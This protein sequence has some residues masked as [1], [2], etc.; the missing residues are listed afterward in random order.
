[1][2]LSTLALAE[3]LPSIDEPLRTGVRSSE[4][5]A[6]VIGIEDYVDLPDVPYATADAE[7]VH[8]LLVYTR[9]IP[10]SRARLLTG[11]VN[12]EAILEAVAEVARETSGRVFVYF[13][14]HGAA[15]TVSGE[16]LLLGFDT[17]ASASSF[18]S[19]A[20]SVSRLLASGPNVVLIADACYGAAGRTGETKAEGRWMVPVKA[21]ER[22]WV[23]AGPNEVAGPLDS[24]AH[25]AFT[26]L[27]VGALRGWADGEQ[28]DKPDGQVTGEEAQLYV[29]R[30][31]RE[32]QLVSQ[33]PSLSSEL[34]GLVFTRGA[35]ERGPELGATRDF[36]RD[37]AE[38]DRRRREREA[39][40]Q[41]EREAEARLAEKEA[42]EARRKKARLEAAESSFRAS[43]AAAWAK[44]EPLAAGG[45]EEG[46]EA[47]ELFLEHYAGGFELDG[48]T[49]PVQL[50][51][52]AEARRA[53]SA[54]KKS[55]AKRPS[56]PA[57]KV[58]AAAKSGGGAASQAP[59][60][61]CEAEAL[62]LGSA[63]RSARLDAQAAAAADSARVLWS[64][65][66]AEAKACEAQDAGKRARCAE[67]VDAFITRT[68]SMTVTLP[69]GTEEVTTR[70]GPAHPAFGPANRLVAVPALEEAKV[71][72]ARL[73]APAPAA[74]NT[75]SAKTSGSGAAPAS[76][77]R[78]VATAPAKEPAEADDAAKTTVR[79]AE[80][81]TTVKAGRSGSGLRLTGTLL[82][83]APLLQGRIGWRTPSRFAF[84]VGV[85]ALNAQWTPFGHDEVAYMAIGGAIFVEPRLGDRGALHLGLGGDY[86]IGESESWV[87]LCSEVGYLHVA[88]NGFTYSL[89]I[90]Q[91]FFPEKAFGPS[92]DLGFGYT[93]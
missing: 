89:G 26:Y 64:S 22:E 49:H 32:L 62:V 76:S 81:T 88:R 69:E 70:C 92:L 68:E 59:T 72:W 37:F 18:D 46:R 33:T 14:G 29:Q 73:A 7:A 15:S 4:D 55:S 3:S 67:R 20:V 86:L 63:A 54:A 6:V 87:S 56:E 84:G 10:A 38:L 23:A 2:I 45:G 25:G 5:G 77:S 80:S 91:S 50:A 24:A 74:G 61:D 35:K 85:S 58:T 79:P 9:G 71:Q 34:A 31:L 83:G 93:W 11:R 66:E 60:P 16:R 13:A 36:D 30:G 82:S 27:M 39:A 65:L 17:L 28:D 90:G 42:E 8:D 12:N 48:Q 40:E 41:A 51:E 1:M 57:T 43:A 52:V 44:A 75:A 21:A 53:A 19:R 78:T 47:A